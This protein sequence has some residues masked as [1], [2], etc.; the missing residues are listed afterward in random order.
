MYYMQKTVRNKKC[1][2]FLLSCLL[3]N[4]LH[5]TQIADT[6]FGFPIYLFIELIMNISLISS[7]ILYIHI[8]I[9]YKH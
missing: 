2:R 5:L 3:F 9:N 7:I 8:R 1:L 6:A 4:T